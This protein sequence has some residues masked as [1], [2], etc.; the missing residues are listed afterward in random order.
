MKKLLIIGKNSYVGTS[1]RA[2]L[3]AAGGFSVSEVGTE[4]GEWRDFD[5]SLFDCVYHVAGIAH[6]DTGSM[7]EAQQANYFSVNTDLAVA[8]AEKAKAAGVRQFIFMSTSL[9]YGRAA[10][11]GDEMRI[12]AESEPAPFNIYG[13]SKLRAEKGILALADESF[14]PLIL[15]CPMIYGKNCKGNFPVMEKYARLAFFFPKI[16]NERSM[17]YIGNLAEYVRLAAENGDEGIFTPCNREYSNTSELIRM[18]RAAKGKKTVLVPGFNRLFALLSRGSNSIAKAFGNFTFAEG[19]G[20]RE[21]DYRVYTL[22]QSIKDT[23]N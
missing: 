21:P 3:E 11:I 22:E 8:C 17:L 23:V 7:S 20:S 1:V 6:S 9:V 19:L 5:F 4:H 16:K 15:R 12:T 2:Y 18:I 14:R 10:R 13:E